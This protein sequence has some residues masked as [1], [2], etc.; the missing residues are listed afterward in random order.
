MRYEINFEGELLKHGMPTEPS[1]WGYSLL[2]RGM[3]GRDEVSHL[4]Y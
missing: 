4:F 2:G 1:N 3:A